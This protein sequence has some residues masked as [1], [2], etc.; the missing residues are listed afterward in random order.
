MMQQR[1]TIALLTA[2]LLMIAACG[3]S[4]SGGDDQDGAR[5]GGSAEPQGE[6]ELVVGGDLDV[7]DY[8][9]SDFY[10]PAGVRIVSVSNSPDT[11]MI[12]LSGVFDE[13]DPATIQADVVAGLQAA[14]YELLGMDEIAVFV[15]NGVG[16]VRVRTSEFLGELT[17][18][19]DIDTW[20]NSQLDELRGLFAE[21]IVVAGTA[22]AELGGLTLTAPGE[23]RLKGPNRAFTATDFSITMQI[24]ETAEPPY[25]YA[26]ITMEDGQGFTIDVASDSDFESSPAM[27]TLSGKMTEFADRDADA[28]EFMIEATCEAS[29]G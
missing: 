28:I 25:V 17:L 12:A 4:E 10:L 2:A 6:E 19:V 13:G 20:D 9:P 18:S 24:D 21:E 15:K 26:D 1:S 3:G 11:Q 8:F 5:D 14:G 29:P 7:P 22:T 23:C 16:R 27:M